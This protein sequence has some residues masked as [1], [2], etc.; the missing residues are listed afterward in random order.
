MENWEVEYRKQISVEN[1]DYILISNW[2]T[3]TDVHDLTNRIREE[4]DKLSKNRRKT[5]L[6]KA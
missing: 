6:R 4:I 3:F 5:E 2:S 1:E